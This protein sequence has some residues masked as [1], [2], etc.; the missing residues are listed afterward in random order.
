MSHT[1]DK[2]TSSFSARKTG[3]NG[4]FPRSFLL[5]YGPAL[6][7]PSKQAIFSRLR[8]F[9]Y[10]WLKRPNIVASEFAMTIE[11]NRPLIC[12]FSGTV[13]TEEFVEDILESVN[14]LIP[15]IQ[16]LNNKDKCNQTPPTREDVNQ[17]LRNVDENSTLHEC[18]MD[19]YNAAG[20]LMMYT[21][22]LLA[23][24]TLMRNTE[25]YAKKTRSSTSQPFKNDPTPK[26]N[27]QLHT[28]LNYQTALC[29]SLTCLS[30]G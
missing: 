8:D 7:N 21:T 27:A 5:N 25:E 11:D 29:N 22:H 12:Q 24:Q 18:V 1:K 23:I 14:E 28:G 26:R 10:E 17:V 3:Y 4:H 19:A 13:F 6:Q 2:S 16:R 20:A 15:A 30:L 9:N